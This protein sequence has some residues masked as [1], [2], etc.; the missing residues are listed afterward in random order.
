MFSVQTDKILSLAQKGDPYARSILLAR[1]KIFVKKTASRICNRVLHWHAD[2]EL[3][4]A[5]NAF[6]ESIDS[7]SKTK[8]EHFLNYA[9]KIICLRLCQHLEREGKL[10]EHAKQQKLKNKLS[11][12]GKPNNR[13]K[14]KKIDMFWEKHKEFLEDHG[15]SREDL[16]GSQ[17]KDYGLVV[18]LKVKILCARNVLK[19]YW[20]HLKEEIG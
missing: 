20:E 10:C 15:I 19:K 8:E 4:V 13:D 5:L 2:K 7:F 12:S 17:Q 16:L 11:L 1:N 3:D 14:R 18:R 6:D 9:E